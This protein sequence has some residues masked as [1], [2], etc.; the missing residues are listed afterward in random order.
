MTDELTNGAAAPQA[1]DQ[2]ASQFMV[3][4]IYVK[5]LSFEVPNAPAVFNMDGENNL[6]MNMQHQITPVSD[7]AFEVVLHL[8]LNCQQGESTIY[9]AEVKQAGVFTLAGFDPQGVEFLLSTQ[10][11]AIL[12]PY[13]RQ[14]LSDL[15]Q[16]GG[17]PPFL[18]QPINFEG[19]YMDAMRQRAEEGAEGVNLEDAAGEP[20]HLDS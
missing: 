7:N 13:A 4:K 16:A 20:R 11:P 18:L 8:T 19:L 2:Q 10:A 6:G 5:D 3:E 12:Y 9:L 17:F 1:E 14:V 15:I